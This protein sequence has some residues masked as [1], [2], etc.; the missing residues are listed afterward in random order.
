MR[1]TALGQDHRQRREA[2][3]V[4]QLGVLEVDPE[5]GLAERDPHQQVDQQAGQP[6]PRRDPDG[7]D[8]EEGDRGAHQQEAVELVDVEGH[9]GHLAEAGRRDRGLP[10]RERR[11]DRPGKAGRRTVRPALLRPHRRSSYRMS[12]ANSLSW[13]RLRHSTIGTT[14]PYA[15][16]AESPVSQCR[17]VL[18][19]EPPGVPGRAG[20]LLQHRAPTGRCSWNARRRGSAARTRPE[21]VGVLLGEPGERAAV[22]GPPPQRRVGGARGQVRHHVGDVGTPA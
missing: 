3:G 5:P 2:Q 16:A 20:E 21:R 7:E 9:R 4:R 18:R 1:Q 14:S 12:C 17:G 22:V 13:V 8:R 10:G 19:V 15:R 6:G 11:I